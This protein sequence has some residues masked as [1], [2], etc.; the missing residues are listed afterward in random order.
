MF[1]AHAAEGI[2]RIEEAHTNWYIVQEGRHLTVVDAGF[3]R[4][5]ASLLDALDRLGRTPA[6]IEAVVLTHGHYDHV[7][8][9][10]RARQELEV[11]VW[12]HER[13][14]PLTRHPWRFDHERPLWRYFRNPPFLKVF[15]EMGAKGALWVK[16]IAEV[17][18]YG[19]SGQL[20]VP[21]RPEIV[22]TPG[23][24]YGHCALHFR[25]RGAVIAG[26]A[27]VMFDPY[28]GRKGPCLVARAATADSR[29]DANTLERLA[30]TGAQ[31]ALTGHGEPWTEGVR[32]A[33]DLAVAAG[34]A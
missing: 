23:H 8:F 10:E 1:Q 18:T 13:E 21:G 22:Y 4:S 34:S 12:A 14:V 16:G 17:T 11:P 33:V 32:I 31:V 29:K 15:A 30:E 19:S 26:D 6:D 24:T 27:F 7:G 3:P 5:W 9:A 20:D 28:T 2:H 25:D